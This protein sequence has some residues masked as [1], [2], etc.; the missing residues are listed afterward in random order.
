MPWKG[1]LENP[2]FSHAGKG[3]SLDSATG[4]SIITVSRP[5]RMGACVCDLWICRLWELGGDLY[6]D[7]N[8]REAC[9]Q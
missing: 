5:F 3:E 1:V 7:E 9:R 4:V 2:I 8:G 6:V